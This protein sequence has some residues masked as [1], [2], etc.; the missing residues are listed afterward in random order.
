[1]I[2]F[3]LDMLRKHILIMLLLPVAILITGHFLHARDLD[4]AYAAV[5][6]SRLMRMPTPGQG[7]VGQVQTFGEMARGMTADIKQ[8]IGRRVE[9]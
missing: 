6:V 2:Y 5:Q 7:Q 3:I 4:P 1:M 8:V 9:Q